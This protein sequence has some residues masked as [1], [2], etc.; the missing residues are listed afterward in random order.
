MICDKCGLPLL[1]T[2]SFCP[3]CGAEVRRP[4]VEGASGHG[5]AA[6]AGPAVGAGPVEAEPE[7]VEAVDVPIVAAPA[8]EAPPPAAQPAP[9]PRPAPAPRPQQAQAPRPA[10]R[11]PARLL[12]PMGLGMLAGCVVFLIAGL[13]LLGVWRGLQLRSEKQAESAAKYYAQGLQYMNQGNY[14]LAI[15]AF[16]YAL[17]LRPNYPEAKQKLDEARA[18]AE[19]RP[20]PTSS[21]QGPPATLLA[22]GR[23]AYDN[24]AWLEAIQKLEAL[25]AAD[26]NYEQATVRRLLVGAYT[27]EGVRLANEDRMEEAIRRFDQALTLQPDNPDVQAQRRL[28]A[29][30][31]S[32]LTAWEADWAQAIKDFSALYTLKPSYKDTAQRLQRA[33]VLAGDAAGTESKWCDA[34]QYYKAAL[35]LAST[36]EL[37]AK[38]DEAA[39]LCALS[40]TPGTPVP[41]GTFVGV[42][43]GQEPIRTNWGKVHGTVLDAQGKPVNGVRVKLSAYDWA[44]FTNTDGNGYYVFEALVNDLTFTV[45]L[46]SVPSKP[47]DVPVKPG[48]ASLANFQEKK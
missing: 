44:A 4:P 37:A 11:L 30:Y 48:Y 15:G 25:Q 43:G 6:G 33:Y 22:E 14:E 21:A 36:P 45:T 17:R 7:V 46:V 41:S 16:E 23:A 18:K 2:E 20:V 32:G 31:Q 24:G 34:V 13:A 9:Q 12:G 27:N 38:R 29:L 26:P 28:A 5:P 40:P 10:S 8:R 35:N 47:L 1:G 42:Y 39:R 19:G 3:Q